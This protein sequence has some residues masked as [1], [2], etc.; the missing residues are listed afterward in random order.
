M[1]DNLNVTQVNETS[2][3][4]PG[5]SLA[6]F[7]METNKETAG[8]ANC[9]QVKD[10][11]DCSAAFTRYYYS[12]PGDA[13]IQFTWTGCGGNKNNFLTEDH[14]LSACT[15]YGASS[16]SMEDPDLNSPQHLCAL[17]A[18]PGKCDGQEQEQDLD[19]FFFS[20]R[21]GHCQHFTFT[22]C[23]G[24]LNNFNTAEACEK[25]CS[26]VMITQTTTVTTD[27]TI[28]DTIATDET[29]EVTTEVTKGVST[30]VSTSVTRPSTSP[31]SVCS[32]PEMAGSCS[33]LLVRFRYVPE[34]ENC[35]KFMF[36]GCGVGDLFTIFR[37][38]Q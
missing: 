17:P 29:T 3:R 22:G 35:V 19:R 27:V 34:K 31:G 30:A 23:Q 25:A 15:G 13:C 12:L 7:V 10:P 21:A 6:G 18:E 1:L 8:R 38:I 37:I 32:L 20:P 28:V 24:N 11:G 5:A 26:P 14:C 33:D 9:L 2:V 16:D 36:T 4:A